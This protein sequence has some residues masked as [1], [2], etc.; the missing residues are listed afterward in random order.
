MIFKCARKDESQAVL[1]RGRT[2]V[3]IVGGLIKSFL[4]L[5]LR[6]KLLVV[7]TI[8]PDIPPHLHNCH[9]A[10]E[11]TAQVITTRSTTCKHTEVVSRVVLVRYLYNCMVSDG[12]IA[13]AAHLR[14]PPSI[15]HQHPPLAPQLI[16]WMP[17]DRALALRVCEGTITVK[18]WLLTAAIRD[19]RGHVHRT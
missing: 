9:T 7:T 1:S 10:A 3:R 19:A 13:V 8:L 17:S 15:Q 2:S 18:G 14:V 11:H 6:H 12:K 5:R 16:M 4:L